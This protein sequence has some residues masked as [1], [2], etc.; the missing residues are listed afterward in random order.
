[1]YVYRVVNVFTA[2]NGRKNARFRCAIRLVKD[3]SCRIRAIRAR[4]I[5]V[6]V[7]F[8]VTRENVVHGPFH[9]TKGTR[10]V[11]LTRDVTRGSV[12][13]IYVGAL[14]AISNDLYVATRNVPSSVLGDE[15]LVM[16]KGGVVCT[17]FVVIQE[18]IVASRVRFR[19]CF[20]H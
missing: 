15:R 10:I 12:S 4:A 17:S 19:S 9:A 5:R 7:L 6:S 8:V 11:F 1:M 13:P 20:L 14:R 18:V 2:I 16:V 3:L